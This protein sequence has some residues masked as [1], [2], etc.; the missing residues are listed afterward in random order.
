MD[1]RLF[2]LVELSR[3]ECSTLIDDFGDAA[4]GTHV[5]PPTGG[6]G[7]AGST[8]IVERILADGLR[9]ISLVVRTSNFGEVPEV[10]H[11]VR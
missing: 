5:W 8:D 4:P 10:W 7:S 1:D 3:H 6:L 11:A 2:A 9:D